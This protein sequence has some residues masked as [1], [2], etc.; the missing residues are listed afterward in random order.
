M[1]AIDEIHKVYIIDVIQIVHNIDV[2]YY[3][4]DIILKV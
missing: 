1:N 3:I 2:S 4:T